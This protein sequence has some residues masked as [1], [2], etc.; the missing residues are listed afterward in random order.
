[1][2]RIVAVAASVVMRA[3]LPSPG[4]AQTPG[5]NDP[6]VFAY[7]K[8]PGNQGIYLALSR[9]GYNYT[10]LNDGQ[11][12]LK[13]DQPGGI[14]R[15]V[16]ITR[17][18]AGTGFRMV[19]TWA[20]RGNSIGISSSPDLLAWSPQQKIDIMHDFPTVANTWAPET[21]WDAARQQWLV[22]WASSF[23]PAPGTEGKGEGLRLWASRTTDWQSFSK[24]DRFFDRGF[25]VIDATLFHRRLRGRDDVVMV[26]KDQTPDPLRYS[27]RWVAGP[28]VEGPWGELS[29]PINESWSEGPS[30][31]QVGDKAVVFYDHYRQPHARYQAVETADWIHWTSADDKLHLPEGCKHGS[32]FRITEAEAQKLLARHDPPSATGAEPAGKG[33]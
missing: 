26:L 8:E 28:S 13:P 15:D 24:P 7:F 27:E 31:L 5:P 17:D 19:F 32:F 22:V 10:A 16:F 23:K 12:W 14:M 25:P 11:P 30:V 1:M 20:W 21:Y 4:Y 29:G 6:V 2:K 3:V 33:R 9:D 18:P